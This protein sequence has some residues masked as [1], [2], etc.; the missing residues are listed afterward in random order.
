MGLQVRKLGAPH[1]RLPHL[2]LPLG[3]IINPRSRHARS[4]YYVYIHI[5]WHV[6]SLLGNDREISN[7]RIAVTR[8]RPVNSNR[9][10]VFSV[11]SMPELY[12]G[13]VG[14]QVR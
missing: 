14:E 11:R 6:D 5:L 1:P 3:N 10:V 12:I 9:G 8:H 13:L 7:Y 4:N 2:P